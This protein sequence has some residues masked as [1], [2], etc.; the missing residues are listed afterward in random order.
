MCMGDTNMGMSR[1]LMPQARGSCKVFFHQD[2]GKVFPWPKQR[3]WQ[4]IQKVSIAHCAFYLTTAY[5]L[6]AYVQTT[7]SLISSL[8]SLFSCV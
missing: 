1:T 5:V 8:T 4:Y 3:Y 6:S 7:P 2:Q